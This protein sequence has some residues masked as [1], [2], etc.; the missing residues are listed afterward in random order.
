MILTCHSHFFGVPPPSEDYLPIERDLVVCAVKVHFATR[1]TKDCNREEFV[2]KSRKT[3]DHAHIWWKFLKQQVHCVCGAHACATW[4]Y[5]A[6][7]QVGVCVWQSRGFGCKK[8]EHCCSV[9]E[10]SEM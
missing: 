8:H 9:D 5:H 2:D 3:V 10:C 1:I 6:Y 7:A 4:L